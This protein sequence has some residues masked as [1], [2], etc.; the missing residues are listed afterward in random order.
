MLAV[1][2]QPFALAETRL[3]SGHHSLILGTRM[4]EGLLALCVLNK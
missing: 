3:T 1:L 4:S 2:R